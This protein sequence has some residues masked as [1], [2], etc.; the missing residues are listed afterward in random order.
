MKVSEAEELVSQLQVAH[1]ISVGFYQ[2]LLPQL[3]RIADKNELDFWSWE[4]LTNKRL[5][6][7]GTS[8]SKRWAWDLLPMFASEHVF[9]KGYGEYAVAGDLVIV[10]RVYLDDNF[11]P[12][13]RKR[14]GFRSEPDSISLPVGKA[15]V[16]V[17]LFCC[18]GSSQHSF[19]T[20]WEQAAYPSE[21]N[22]QWENVGEMMKARKLV[23]SL[24]QF[25]SEPDTLLE[26]ISGELSK[27]M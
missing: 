5:A 26:T 7:S 12:P 9:G 27:N 3:D 14:L 10:F 13:N 19:E 17:L 21:D 16:E 6:A 15:V 11:K 23:F 8:P 25:I 24:A 18:K 22:S 1:R 20:L 4:Q 2:W